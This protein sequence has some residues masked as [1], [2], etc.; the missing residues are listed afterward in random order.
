[1]EVFLAITIRSYREGD[2]ECVGIL[3]ADTYRTFN[4][5]FA[6]SGEQAQLLGPFQHATSTE[7]SHREA[8]A[9]AIHAPM[10][11]VAEEDG[12]IVGVLRGGRED[13]SG[14]QCR[15]LQSLFVR[16]SHH[17]RGIGRR[18][19]RLFEQACVEQEVQAIRVA[20]TLFAVPFYLKMGYKRTTGVRQGHSFE[21]CGLPY[22]PMK[23][24]DLSQEANRWTL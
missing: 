21:G 18:L 15:V 17:R 16:G 6:S 3:I 13:R 20:A 19:I 10:V 8:I 22:Q 24:T 4:L 2:A 7:V 14:P 11:F 5:T 1:L 12:E 9:Q 23:R